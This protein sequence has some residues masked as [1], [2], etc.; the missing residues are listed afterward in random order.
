MSRNRPAASLRAKAAW[1]ALALAASLAAVP[2]AAQAQRQTFTVASAKELLR[3][4]GPN[5]TIVLKKG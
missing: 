1:L 3:A 4:V 2:A 5:R